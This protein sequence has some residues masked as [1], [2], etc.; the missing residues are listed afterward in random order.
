MDEFEVKVTDHAFAAMEEIRDYISDILLNPSAAV[1]HMELFREKIK[2]LAFAPD[3]I[4]PIDEQPRHDMGVRKVRV[5]N[6]YIYYWVEDTKNLVH[7]T[8]V[9]YVGADQPKWLKDMPL[10]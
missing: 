10:E 3:T 4:K 2:E 1:S 8:D 7:V 6:F 5:K 9:I